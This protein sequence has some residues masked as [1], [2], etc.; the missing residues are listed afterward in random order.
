MILGLGKSY[1]S[2]QR[3]DNGS[4]DDETTPLLPQT[5]ATESDNPPGKMRAA[6]WAAL[7]TLFTVALVV[8]L[9]FPQIV[10]DALAPVIGRLPKD[11]MRAAL[12]ILD[13]APVIVSAV[14]LLTP[15]N[16]R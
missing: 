12:R 3:I 4:A 16:P 2:T 15:R 6:V 11:P 14:Q 10:P 7:T 1:L 5:V 13:N 8:L 9:F